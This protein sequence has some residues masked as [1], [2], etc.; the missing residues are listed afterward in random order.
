MQYENRKLMPIVSPILKYLQD[1]EHFKKQY[2]NLNVDQQIDVIE[3][4]LDVAIDIIN[5]HNKMK[6]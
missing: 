6:G 4:L 2:E 1:N 3:D 5:Q